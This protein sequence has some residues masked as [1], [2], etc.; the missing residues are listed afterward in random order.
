MSD[1]VA[2]SPLPLAAQPRPEDS[3]YIGAIRSNVQCDLIEIT[4]DKLRVILMKHAPDL[5]LRGGWL[6]P[7]SLFISLALS[8]LT[9]STF[10]D[11]FGV[12]ASVWTALFLIGTVVTLGWSIAALAKL[13]RRRKDASIDSII[14]RIKNA[15]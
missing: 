6:T 8:Q 15:R 11:K 12:T 13:Y 1:D 7:T 4:E 3:K 5:A 14:E 10:V 2:G 9:T